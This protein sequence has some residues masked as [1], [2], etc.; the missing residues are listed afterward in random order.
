MKLVDAGVADAVKTELLKEC[1]GQLVTIWSKEKGTFVTQLVKCTEALSKHVNEARAKLFLLPSRFGSVLGPVNEK[2]TQV[3]EEE[4]GKCPLIVVL[5]LLLEMPARADAALLAALL[6][7]VASLV[8]SANGAMLAALSE[9]LWSDP[10]RKLLDLAR[11]RAE[12]LLDD[13]TRTSL[14]KPELDENAVY[15]PE[16]LASTIPTS[17]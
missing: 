11:S 5:P 8:A 2:W 1:R 9:I 6:N 15:N 3:Y 12:G 16:P 7:L 13:I 10:K 4:Q 17:L 14:G